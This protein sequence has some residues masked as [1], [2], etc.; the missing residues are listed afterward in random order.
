VIAGV[1][2]AFAG[3]CIYMDVDVYQAGGDIEAGNINF[4]RAGSW[5]NMLCDRSNLVVLDGNIPN[6]IDPVFRV[7]DMAALEHKVIRR[8]PVK[9]RRQKR[10]Q[11]RNRE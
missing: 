2:V 4:L 8:L 9:R 7:D 1:G 3:A 10:K 6:R 5:L 11:Q